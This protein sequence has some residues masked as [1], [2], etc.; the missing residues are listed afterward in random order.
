[1]T[2]RRSF[3]TAQLAEI[4][5]RPVR[6]CIDWSEKGIFEADLHSASGPGSRRKFSYGAVLR[7]ALGL[8]L[9][10]QYSFSRAKIKE[11]LELLSEWNFFRYWDGSLETK[12]Q[13]IP[14]E[15]GWKSV[16][17]LESDTM[18]LV[19][20]NTAGQ[21]KVFWSA[22]SLIEAL[23]HSLALIGG[24]NIDA[25]DIVGFDLSPIKKGIDAKIALLQ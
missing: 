15:G 4:I 23:N 1:M 21:T 16:S 10:N 19:I 8:F 18:S 14:S 3:T 24:R 7:A 11:I 5:N 12:D 22:G 2:E 17:N 13:I 6:F 25:S 9:Q 20:I